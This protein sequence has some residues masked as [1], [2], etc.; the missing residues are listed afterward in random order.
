MAANIKL[1]LV[2][3]GINSVD[4]ST[5]YR[6]IY[7][8]KS[9]NNIIFDEF[10]EL[11]I[12]IDEMSMVSMLLFWDLLQ[13]LAGVEKLRIIFIGDSNQL[14][15]IESGNVFEDLIVKSRVPVTTL[16]K[17]Y[18]AENQILVYNAVKA[19]NGRSLRPD[20]DKL[21]IIRNGNKKNILLKNILEIKNNNMCMNDTCVISPAR[22]GNVGCDNINNI[23]QD[24]HNKV[25]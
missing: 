17:Q 3:C 5:I 7:A 11:H 23:L 15:C 25:E 14:S 21:C 16:I 18:R 10:N 9:K 8:S 19:L 6:F 12:F 2:K 22:K 24:S 4:C 20:G 1:E 13:F